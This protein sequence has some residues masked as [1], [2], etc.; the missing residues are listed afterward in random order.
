MAANEDEPES[1]EGT[2]FELPSRLSLTGRGSRT[3][4]LRPASAQLI[5]IGSSENGFADAGRTF[6]LTGVKRVTF[7]R[8]AGDKILDTPNGESLD[9][10]VPVPWVSG[11]HAELDISPQPGRPP[12]LRL[13]DLGS[14]NGTAIEGTRLEGSRELGYGQLFELGRSFWIIRDVLEGHQPAPDFEPV[15]TVAPAL[16]RV[17]RNLFRLARTN[18]PLLLVGETGTGKDYIARVIHRHSG[19]KGQFVKI[20]LLGVSMGELLMGEAGQP[21]LLQ[22]AAGGTVYV[23]ELASL[24]RD[25][26]TKLGSLLSYADDEDSGANRDIR[27]IAS[28][29]KDLRRLV[30]EG[31]FRPDL[32]ARL[33]HYEAHLPPL[34]ERREDLGMILGRLT[35]VRGASPLKMET[36]A[37][38]RIL[39]H[40]WPFNLRELRQAIIAVAALAEEDGVINATTLSQ[41]LRQDAGLPDDPAELQRIRDA[42]VEHMTEHRGNIAVVARLMG[43]T[44]EELQRILRSFHIDPAKFTGERRP[45]QS[46]QTLVEMSQDAITGAVFDDE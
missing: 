32:Y 16:V 29:T 17:Y 28:S 46:S 8:V 31:L 24:E 25:A 4:G 2:W 7:G 42:L 30:E 5:Y 38:R 27:V 35:A 9:L 22:Q 33:A 20:N 10:G 21:G 3:G 36:P 26:Q 44:A 13:T 11:S 1:P 18:M 34:R 15:G 37:F 12:T 43:K 41:V 45:G 14:R 19:R 23:D 40:K 6:E 39:G